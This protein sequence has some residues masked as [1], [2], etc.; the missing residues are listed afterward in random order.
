MG[1]A[2][3]TEVGAQGMLGLRR[4]GGSGRSGGGHSRAG[5][6]AHLGAV[7]SQPFTKGSTAFFYWDSRVNLEVSSTVRAPR[8]LS[9]PPP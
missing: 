7:P 9:S 6:T 3:P 2:G 1:S 4:G 5:G 8:S